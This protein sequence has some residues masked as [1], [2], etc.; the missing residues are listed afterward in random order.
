MNESTL[1]A[2]INVLERQVKF[3]RWTIGG[4]MLAALVV[5]G[6][7]ATTGDVS[8][9]LKTKKLTVVNDKG[10][11]AV[12]IAPEKDGGIVAVFGPQG[13]IP[14]IVLASQESGGE[15]L[16]K[17]GGGVNRIQMTGDKDN[18]KVTVW[19]GSQMRE[20]SGGSSK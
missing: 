19:S 1:E 9:E 10:E 3:Q 15:V 8:N 12:M 16:V 7:A 4:L 2:R 20:L 14:H 6:V 17:G 18:G 13:R 5:G 11:N